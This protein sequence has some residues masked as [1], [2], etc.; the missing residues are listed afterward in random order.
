MGGGGR[1]ANKRTTYVVKNKLRV[2][3]LLY[4][5]LKKKKYKKTIKKQF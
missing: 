3:N 4:G 1:G 2:H 5:E